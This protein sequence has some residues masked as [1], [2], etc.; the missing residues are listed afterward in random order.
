MCQHL[1]NQ[2][3]YIVWINVKWHQRKGFTQ[4]YLESPSPKA[5]A[6]LLYVL[7]MFLVNA[8]PT[9]HVTKCII[10]SSCPASSL[11]W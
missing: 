8:I 7:K 2:G 4:W 5:E 9:N 6:G 3:D 10:N 11:R 1:L